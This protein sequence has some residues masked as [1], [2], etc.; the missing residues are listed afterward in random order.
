V[1]RSIAADY[2]VEITTELLDGKAHDAIEKY[3]LKHNASLLVIGK[4]GIHADD[5]LDIGGNAENLLRNVPCGILISQSHFTPQIDIVAEATTTWTHQA[6]ERMKK[7]PSFAQGMAKMAILRYAQERGHTVITEGIVREAT[8]ALCPVKPGAM[9]AEGT[10]SKQSAAVVDHTQ[11]YDPDWSDEAEQLLATIR[12]QSMRNN[13][14]RRA[15]KK[16]R[17]EKSNT[18]ECNHLQAFMSVPKQA[19]SEAEKTLDT[20]NAIPP[21]YQWSE[22][23]LAKLE[24][25]PEGGIRDMARAAAES[26]AAESAIRNIDGEFFGSILDTFKSGSEQ[27]SETLEWSDS[28]RQGIAKAPAMVRGMLIREIE[29]FARDRGVSQV[30]ESTVAEVKQRW[31]DSGTFHQGTAD[32]R[33]Y[34]PIEHSDAITDSSP[35]L[36]WN[37]EALARLNQVPE[38]FMRESCRRRIE[39]FAQQQGLER[40]DLALVKQQLQSAYDVMES[41]VKNGKGKCPLGHGS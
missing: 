41:V 8:D 27:V 22:E 20:T 23:A 19:V 29:T 40:I 18:V 15:E 7:I 35:D 30:D 31:G 11:P 17:Q 39:S 9:S 34:S 5:E 13:L 37:S 38:G 36:I 6:E 3:V 32:P 1:A 21:S 25:V 33:A 2:S 28:A 16:A 24:R 26:I 4:L 10:G 14:R 12:D